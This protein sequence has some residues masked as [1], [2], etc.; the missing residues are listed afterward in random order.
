MFWYLKLLYV[1][2]H[3]KD[4]SDSNPTKTEKTKIDF[5]D[6]FVQELMDK[7]E[8]LTKEKSDSSRQYLE[9]KKLHDES[10][11][12]VNITQIL[13]TTWNFKLDLFGLHLIT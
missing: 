11:R 9:E 4:E 1:G 7:I 10:N 6:A 3:T 13:E 2:Y 12:K 5:D 8:T